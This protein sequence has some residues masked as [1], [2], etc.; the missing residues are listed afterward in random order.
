VSSSI[1]LNLNNLLSTSS[2]NR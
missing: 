1:F 2:G